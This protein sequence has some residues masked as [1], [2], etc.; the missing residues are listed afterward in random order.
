MGGPLGLSI[1]GGTDHTSH[2]FGIEDRGVFI[3]KIVPEGAAA[4]TPLRIGD[5]I[6]TVSRFR[7]LFFQTLTFSEISFTLY[8]GSFNLEMKRT[9][10]DFTGGNKWF[11]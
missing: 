2:P 10:V 8:I 6:L 4:R 3:S 1:V 11:D 9:D 5:R 7:I